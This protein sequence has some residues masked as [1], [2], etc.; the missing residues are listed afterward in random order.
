MT[1]KHTPISEIGEFGLI[2][3][4]K[5]KCTE[6]RLSKKITDQIILGIE[7]DTAVTRPSPGMLQLSTSDLLIEGVHFDLT[8][9]SMK[10]LG[11]KLMVANLSDIAA[12]GGVP[13]HA[14]ITIALPSKISVE[15][16]EELY[17]G[18]MQAAETYSCAIIG[19]DTNTSIGNTMLS[20]TI[21]G[22]VPDRFLKRRNGAKPGDLIC[23]TGNLGLSH[24]GLQ[25]LLREKKRYLEAEHGARFETQ[26]EEYTTAVSKHLAP[27][28]RFD[29]SMTAAQQVWVHAM[30]DISDGLASDL[31]H[32][33]NLSNAGALIYEEK[34][35]IKP[36]VV[37]IADEFK[38]SAI[39]YALFGGEEYELL[40]TIDPDYEQEIGHRI[41]DT[42]IIGEIT[43]EKGTITLIQNNGA[44]STITSGGYEH[45][46]Q[47]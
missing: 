28:A 6:L 30:I 46:R 23:L 3:R 19:G 36:L 9:T 16:V 21:T 2:E 20:A 38:H 11:W 40:F 43:E 39:Q 5:R 7:D 18:I 37:K 26:L 8:Y 1:H 44:K 13:L 15:M 17:D 32:I 27:K 25:V 29:I 12:M 34:I 41:T 45:F 14:L 35:P 10:H 31:R 22:E 24:A 42:S 47:V 33:C 4:L